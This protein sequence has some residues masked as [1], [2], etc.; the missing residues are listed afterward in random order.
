M[1][2]WTKSGPITSIPIFTNPSDS[3][4]ISDVRGNVADGVFT[5]SETGTYLKVN[6]TNLQ[7]E[8]YYIGDGRT[9]YVAQNGTVSETKTAPDA[10]GLS[11]ASL[12][13]TALADPDKVYT[14]AGTTDA[15][16]EVIIPYTASYDVTETV[17][18]ELIPLLS[19]V[20]LMLIVVFIVFVVSGLAVR[21]DY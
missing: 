9:Y 6:S 14:V 11:H 17:T 5:P 18:K 4:T 7:Y 20:P 15:G 2:T 13:F 12:T 1:T 19:A 3:V 21:R 8:T 16:Y 10:T